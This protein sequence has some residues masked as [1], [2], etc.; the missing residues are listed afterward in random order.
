MIGTLVRE[1]PLTMRFALEPYSEKLVQEMRPLWDQHN[2]EIPQLGLAIDP[3]VSMY[4]KLSKVLSLRIFTA[5]VGSGWE[6]TLV[7][8][9][10]F[11]VMRHPHRKYNLEASQDMIW[12]DPEVRKGMVGAK[13]IRWADEQLEKEGVKAIHRQISAQKD[14]GHLLERRGYRLMDLTYA[15]VVGG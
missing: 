14:F 1:D 7:G 11:F 6:S 8:Y 2:A 13:F 4:S 10:I 5:R 12:L 9:Q 3:D 15:R